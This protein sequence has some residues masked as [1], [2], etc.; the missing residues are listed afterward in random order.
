VWSFAGQTNR[1]NVN[2]FLVQPFINFNLPRGWAVAT[3]P[4]I[5]AN[6]TTTQGRWAVPVGLSLSNTFKDA[7]QLMSLAVSYYSYVARPVSAPQTQLRVQW[8]L[9]YPIRRGINVEELIKEATGPQ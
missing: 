7:G 1:P 5:T 8:S 6:W 4:S 9:L 3:A 2:A